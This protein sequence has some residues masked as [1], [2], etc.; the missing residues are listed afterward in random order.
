M[1]A[2]LTQRSPYTACMLRAG[3]A[4]TIAFTLTACGMKG[5]LYLPPETPAASTAAPGPAESDQAEADQSDK[6]ERKT[7][8]ATPDP[9]LSR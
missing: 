6:G 2:V 8:P 3:I 9:S 1:R 4:L 5:D 7:I